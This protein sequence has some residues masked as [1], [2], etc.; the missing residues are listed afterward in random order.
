MRNGNLLP[1]LDGAQKVET[2]LSL[3]LHIYFG[4]IQFAPIKSMQKIKIAVVRLKLTY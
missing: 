4:C 2:V 1:Q 3:N